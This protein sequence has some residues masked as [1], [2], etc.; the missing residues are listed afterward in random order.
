MTETLLLKQVFTPGGQPSITYV[1]RDH[2]GLGRKL[3]KAGASLTD[4]QLSN[5]M[6]ATLPSGGAC[7]KFDGLH[8][9]A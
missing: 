8:Q 7:G 5:E 3:I 6:D 4:G 9:L 2:L 1:S